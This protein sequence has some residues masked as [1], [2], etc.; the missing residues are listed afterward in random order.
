LE[1]GGGV[2]A[3]VLLD[4]DADKEEKEGWRDDPEKQYG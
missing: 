4:V 1:P 2:V 3:V